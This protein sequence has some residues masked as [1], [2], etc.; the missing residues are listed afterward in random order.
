MS[1]KSVTYS[2]SEVVCDKCGK[3][4]ERKDYN[5][6]PHFIT[7]HLC[8]RDFCFPCYHKNDNPISVL[9]E[10][11]NWSLNEKFICADCY[12]LIKYRYALQEGITL[13]I[14]AQKA[15]DKA[16]SDEFNAT[17]LIEKSMAPEAGKSNGSG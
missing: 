1:E 7:C 9:K 14:Q 8:K 15:A 3:S 11:Y 10:L 5:G 13:Y 4:G 12:D 16:A 6:S 17:A 2:K